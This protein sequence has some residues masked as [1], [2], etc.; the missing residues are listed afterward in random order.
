MNPS[1]LESSF[2]LKQ[3]HTFYEQVVR[4]KA[5][6]AEIESGTAELL[7]EEGENPEADRVH[8]VQVILIKVPRFKMVVSHLMKHFVNDGSCHCC[9]IT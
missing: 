5:I 9:G 4:Q 6:V 2:L 7:A 1:E 8:T 3:F